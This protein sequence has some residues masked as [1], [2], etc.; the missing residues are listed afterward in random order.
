MA[1]LAPGAFAPG[2]AYVHP[3]AHG[4]IPE[5]V[6]PLRPA[7]YLLVG[8]WAPGDAEGVRI[9]FPFPIDI[10]WSELEY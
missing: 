1:G 9:E 5:G 7:N 6:R 3:P 8:E 2:R 10:P 4:R